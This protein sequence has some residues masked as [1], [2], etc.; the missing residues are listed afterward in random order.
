MPLIA[1]AGYP[2]IGCIAIGAAVLCVISLFASGSIQTVLR[3]SAGLGLFLFLFSL[4]FFRDPERAIPSDAGVLLAPADGA[5]ID[6]REMDE[7]VYLKTKA[8]RV[9]IFMSVFNVHV[10]R[11]PMDGVV[12]F[13]KYNPGTFISAFKDKASDEN[14]SIFAGIK[15]AD[16]AVRISVKFIAGLIARRIA[17]YKK[18]NDGIRQGERINMI[19]FGSRVDIFCP[20]GF[21]H[22]RKKR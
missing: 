11:A 7:P 4:Y 10:N 13:L 9:S 3:I 19:R 14:E 18:V 20:A 1:R 12:D 16:G 22:T 17:F 15:S 8:V 5:V 2:V 6:I 21:H